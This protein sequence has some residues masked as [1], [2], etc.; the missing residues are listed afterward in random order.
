[1]LALT[2]DGNIEEYNGDFF[3]QSIGTRG[4]GR[5]SL[6]LSPLALYGVKVDGLPNMI[7]K[8]VIPELEEAGC[9]IDNTIELRGE[10]VCDHEWYSLHTDFDMNKTVWRS[11]AAGMFNRDQPTNVKYLLM[12]L[13]NLDI[14]DQKK[15]LVKYGLLGKKSPYKDVKVVYDN[16]EANIMV[17]CKQDHK[18]YNLKDQKYKGKLREEQLTFISYSIAS[19]NGN[20]DDELAIRAIPG[21]KYIMDIPEFKKLHAITNNIDEIINIIDLFYGTKNFIRDM[22]LK[23]I[24][25]FI[26]YSC[27]GIVLKRYGSCKKTQKLD[28]ILK[29][30]KW[31]LPKEPA[32]QVA[33]KL[34]TDPVKSKIIKIIKKVTSLGNTT[35]S[36]EIEPVNIEG[37]LV[38]NVN[39]H[40]EN[41]LSVPENQW[42]KEGAECNVQLSLDIIPIISKLS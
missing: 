18:F 33:I 39:L 14:K 8:E 21:V 10:A 12:K 25:S 34:P 16:D 11:I 37:T 28:P 5:N 13:D 7:P 32:D 20:I 26:R 15:L 27:D 42:I 30:G 41:W 31:I 3:L 4:D 2:E 35:V 19:V 40:N 1:M 22:N 38:K 9:I 23:R 29:H 17:Q 24:K 36:A 6:E